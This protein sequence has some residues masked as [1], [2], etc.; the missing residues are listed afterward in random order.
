[1]NPI[2]LCFDF[3]INAVLLISIVLLLCVNFEMKD[4]LLKNYI[5]I[6]ISFS[7]ININLVV[8][9]Y[10]RFSKVNFYII[11]ILIPFF[12]ANIVYMSLEIKKHYLNWRQKI[13]VY[14][15]GVFLLTIIPI[16]IYEAFLIILEYELI[17]LKLGEYKLISV[18]LLFLVNAI[19]G[20]YYS[21]KYISKRLVTDESAGKKINKFE[22]FEKII[23][24]K[25]ITK[26]EK[27]IMSLI[28]EGYT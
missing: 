18:K 13:V 22:N 12:I 5:G 14:F 20:I 15:Y 17:N 4:R 7:I 21:I 11:L 10:T 25:N 28:F 27:E 9:F 6:C 16:K 3:V 24:E 2:L 19:I 26:R 23:V 8:S 1:M